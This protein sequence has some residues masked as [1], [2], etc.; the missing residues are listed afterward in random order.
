VLK[1]EKEELRYPDS[2]DQ[3]WPKELDAPNQQKVV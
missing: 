3:T 1:E 2:K